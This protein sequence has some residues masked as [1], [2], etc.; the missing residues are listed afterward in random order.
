MIFEPND[1]KST[2]ESKAQEI[3]KLDYNIIK[4]HLDELLVWLQDINWPGAKIIADLLTTI[5]KPLI[6][7]IKK[8]LKTD[9]GMWIYWIFEEIINNWSKEL[10]IEIKDELILLTNKIDYEGVFIKALKILRENELIDNDKFNE[11]F[12][13]LSFGVKNTLDLFKEF[14]DDLKSLEN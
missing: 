7:S 10:I 4:N 2:W 5:G 8:V 1:N 14:Y 3:A 6:P 9:D 12:Q 13:N 11:I